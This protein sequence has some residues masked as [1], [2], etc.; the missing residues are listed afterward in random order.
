MMLSFVQGGLGA[1][2]LLGLYMWLFTPPVEP[3]EW[4]ASIFLVCG[5]WCLLAL[6]TGAVA[7]A[8]RVAPC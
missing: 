6:L 3:S 4:V 7:F 8:L 2:I 5:V 1:G